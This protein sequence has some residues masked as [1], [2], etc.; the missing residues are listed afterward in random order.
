[1]RLV[2]VLWTDVKGSELGQRG[3]GTKT[4]L[5]DIFDFVVRDK[6]LRDP[7][8]GEGEGLF[9]EAIGFELVAVG[10]TAD[11]DPFALSVQ[12]EGTGFALGSAERLALEAGAVH[13]VLGV[14][15][16]YLWRVGTHPSVTCAALVS[17]AVEKKV[18]ENARWAPEEAVC[19]ALDATLVLVKDED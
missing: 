11:E 15:V 13:V 14:L 5:L 18:A 17:F 16:D 6:V 12:A 7:A 8:Y 3:R 2:E 1:V 4:T 10:E 9:H 19:P